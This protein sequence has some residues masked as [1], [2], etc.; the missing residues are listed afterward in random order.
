VRIGTFSVWTAGTLC[1]ALLASPSAFAVPGAPKADSGTERAEAPAA[2]APAKSPGSAAQE[3]LRIEGPPGLL[4]R[5][6]EAQRALAPLKQGLMSTLQAALAEGPVAAVDACRLAAPGIAEG[7]A[8]DV[9]AVGRTS[10]RLRNPDN[11]PE[12]WMVPLLE[13]Y[14]EAPPDPPAGTVV[15]LE[16]DRIG[17]VEPI[18]VKPLCTTCHGTSVDEA[19]LAHIRERYPEDRA[20]GYSVGDFRG[21]FWV[22]AT[23]AQ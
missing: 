20:T 9:Y 6:R 22:V 17:Y 10:D 8:T 11:A 21:L 19:L 12:P 2:P 18:H 4:A 7:A 15:A 16:G 3:P 23:P 5:A 14:R 13:R 1:V